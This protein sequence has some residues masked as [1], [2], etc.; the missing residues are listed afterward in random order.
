ME[1][2]IDKNI[3]VM[4]R[5]IDYFGSTVPLQTGARLPQ[6]ISLQLD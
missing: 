3:A 5:M 1:F 4:G 6:Q 2:N